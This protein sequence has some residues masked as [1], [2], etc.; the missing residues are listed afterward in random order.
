MEIIRTNIDPT[1]KRE[2]YR[3]TKSEAM[4]A[5]D[6]ERGTSAPVEKWCL[7]TEEAQ[8]KDGT[9]EPRDVLSII[10]TGGAKIS[11]ISGTFIR[12]FLEIVEIMGDE[13]FS[14][15]FTG[16]K[17]KG[18]REYVNCTLDCDYKPETTGEA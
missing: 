9:T 12:S 10:F 8:K 15:V 4:R 17:S 11:T 1:N 13:P 6:M 3:L 18:G 5:Q 14:I 16:G 7:Y 2:L